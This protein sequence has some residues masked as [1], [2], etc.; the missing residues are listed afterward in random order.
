ML[1]CGLAIMLGVQAFRSAQRGN[2]LA[3]LMFGTCMLPIINGQFGQPTT[4]GFAVFSAGLCL[5]AAQSDL[6]PAAAS[7]QVEEFVQEAAHA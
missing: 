3:L 2:Y 6:A 4:C 5:A 7:P 1:R